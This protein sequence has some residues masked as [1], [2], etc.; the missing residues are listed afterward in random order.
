MYDGVSATVKEILKEEGWVGLTRGMGPQIDLGM[1]LVSFFYELEMSG[2]SSVLLNKVTEFTFQWTPAH[3]RH[4]DVVITA[5]TSCT[6]TSNLSV[7]LG[8]ALVAKKACELGLQAIKFGVVRF[9]SKLF[10]LADCIQPFSYGITCFVPNNEIV[11]LRHS[12]NY[13]LL[14]QSQSNEDLFVA[15]V[16]MFTS[17][18]TTQDLLVEQGLDQALEDEKL[19]SIN[20]TKW[21][22]IQRRIMS[23]IRLTFAP[24]IKHNVL[25]ETT[26]KALWE[27]L[28]N[29]YASKS[30]T[31]R[32]YDKLSDE[33]QALLLLASLPRSF[34]ALVQTLL[35]GRSTLNLD[36]VT[37][38]LRENERMMR[39][40]N[41]DDKHNAI[42][43]ME[44]E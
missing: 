11:D 9:I 16:N 25:K 40:N 18:S 15:I 13:I 28:E 37:T 10:A 7:M 2:I 42:A 44:F 29:I 41:V 34:K 36:E 30:L 38:A 12:V 21:T 6:N 22:K 17:T 20:E 1:A 35:V 43:V 3:L 31:N 19:A 5:I 27:K 32:L 26:P 39:T 14:E 24:E 23:T 4:D 33:E 8:A